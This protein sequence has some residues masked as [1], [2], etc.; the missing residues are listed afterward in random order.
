MEKDIKLYFKIYIFWIYFFIIKSN[1]IHKL[2]SL[3]PNLA[4]LPFK[5]H[6]NPYNNNND[7]FSSM[8]YLENIHSSIAYLE[9]ETGTSIKHDIKLTKEI[10]NRIK[11]QKQFLTIFLIIDD[12]T[13]Y[14]DENYF[15]DDEKNLICR[16]SRNLSTSYEIKNDL[17]SKYRHSIYASDYFKVYSDISLEKYNMVKMIFRHSL[18]LNKNISFSCGKAGLLYNS[19]KKDDYSDFNFI[20]QIHSNI[21]N[22]D[23][24]FLFKFSEVKQFEESEDGLLIIGAESYLK[25]NNSY[26]IYSIYAK[27]KYSM[28]LQEWRFQ[29]DRLIIGN[30]NN[31]INNLEFIITFGFEGIEIPYNIFE[32]LNENFFNRYYKNNICMYEEIYN[33]YIIIYCYNNYFTNIEIGNFPTIQFS[34]KEIGYN[35]SFVGEELFYKKDN[36]YFFKLI[37]RVE[38]NKKEIKLGRMFLK[39]YNVIFNSD[40]KMMTFYRSNNLNK[41][42]NQKTEN[43]EQKNGFLVFLSYAFFC[44]LFLIIG[45]Y[46]G[47]KYCI[48]RRKRFANE[49]E[50]YNYE[51]NPD[52]K[53]KGKRKLIN[54]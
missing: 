51:Y 3:S 31:E 48:M 46:F 7:V 9:I 2:N 32:A 34:I 19:E 43:K 16:Y 23:Y 11:D 17:Q 40:T 37:T 25:N 10:E 38:V 28:S 54:F 52:K 12:F 29:G 18:S 45:F 26:E 22:V 42:N 8:N 41:Q 39:K 5:Y 47:R 4:V 1:D 50:D 33:Y 49:L 6:H 14:I 15:Y 30:I 27:S 35:F 21:N 24:S 20:H 36:K 13:F 53:D 44:I